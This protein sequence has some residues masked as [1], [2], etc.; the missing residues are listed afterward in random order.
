MKS[1]IDA[2]LLQLILIHLMRSLTVMRHAAGRLDP[3]HFYNTGLEVGYMQLYAVLLKYFK[4]YNTLPGKAVLL[5]E[6]KSSLESER[7][8]LSEVQAQSVYELVEIAFSDSFDDSDEN[9]ASWAIDQLTVFLTER[10]VLGNLRQG[11]DRGV[12]TSE[13]ITKLQSD[14]A[15]SCLSG[16]E[17]VDP[18][19]I[20]DKEIVARKSTGVRWYDL[21][22]GGGIY[23]SGGEVAGFLAG[24]GWGKTF[25]AIQLGVGLAKRDFPVLY[26]SYEQAIEG[27]MAHDITHR[28]VSCASGVKRSSLARGSAGLTTEEMSAVR[29]ASDKMNN[30]LSLLDMSGV[31]SGTGIGGVDELEAQLMKFSKKGIHI[32]MVIVDWF[33]NMVDKMLAESNKNVDTRMTRFHY[34]QEIGKAIVLSAKYHTNFLMMHQSNT[35]AQEGSCSRKPNQTDAEEARNFPQLMQFCF[36]LGKPTKEQVSILSMVKARATSRGDVYVKLNGELSCFETMETMIADP[37]SGLPIEADD[38]DKVLDY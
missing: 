22:T 31:H 30:R 8:M 10:V 4:K 23:D 6:L 32:K 18:F 11:M 29:R 20:W 37:R 2:D 5:A 1:H 28:V 12:E 24:T 27:R 34:K 38:R 19:A 15:S 26:C 13:L 3:A 33:G 25:A 36:A 14:Y 17:A 16:A 35:I 9:T 21:L 7:S